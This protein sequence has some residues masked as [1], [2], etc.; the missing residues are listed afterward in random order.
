M[1]LMQ[2]KARGCDLPEGVPPWACSRRGTLGIPGG[3]CGW[4]LWPR[5]PGRR[6]GG[7]QRAEAGLSWSPEKQGNLR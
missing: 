3:R 6:S 7:I 2:P 5:P 4:A 1:G